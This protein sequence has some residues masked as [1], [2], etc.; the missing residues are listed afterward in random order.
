MRA[1]DNTNLLDRDTDSTTTGVHRTHEHPPEPGVGPTHNPR[2]SA[3][4]LESGEKGDTG[5]RPLILKMELALWIRSCHTWLSAGAVPRAAGRPEGGDLPSPFL[6]ALEVTL[7]RR[8]RRPP[9]LTRSNMTAIKIYFINSKKF[10]IFVK[11]E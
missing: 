3:L 11:T 7:S 8:A 2:G 10:F 4:P 5:R 9:T 6:P 1:A